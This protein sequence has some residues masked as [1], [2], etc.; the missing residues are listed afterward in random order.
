MSPC[1]NLHPLLNRYHDGELSRRQRARV[2]SHLAV[3]PQCAAE[4]A[5]IR[6]LGQ[7]LRQFLS[8]ECAA[9]DF[10]GFTERVMQGISRQEPLPLAARVRL[11]LG[12]ALRVYRP[13]WLASVAAATAAVLLIALW[14]GAP[15]NGLSEG[16]TPTAPAVANGETPQPEGP[17]VII[18]RMEYAGERSMIF[19]VSRNNTTVIW[20]YD[21]NRLPDGKSEGD[22]L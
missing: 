21:M 2:E 17:Q 13:V 20:L 9:V 19:S 3:C 22:D 5:R 15:A 14:P 1:E 8:D 16:K 11:W 6:E 12:E 4:L 18:D 7:G 10:S